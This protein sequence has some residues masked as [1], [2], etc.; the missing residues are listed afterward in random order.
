MDKQVQE[1]KTFP[2]PSKLGK[3]LK[4]QSKRRVQELLGYS[5]YHSDFDIWKYDLIQNWFFRREM[6]LFFAGE[7]LRDILITDYFLG[8]KIKEY[9][10]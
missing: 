5:N 6:I 7:E 9:I 3:I 4:E 2:N 8:N 1:I 10:Y